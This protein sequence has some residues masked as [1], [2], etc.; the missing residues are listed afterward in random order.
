MLRYTGRNE[1]RPY[2]ENTVNMIGHDD[3]NICVDLR[4]PVGQFVPRFLYYSSS[5]VQ[6]H[7]T[8]NHRAKQTRS[9]LRA[10][11]DEIGAGLAVIV[12]L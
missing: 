6:L 9:V 7:S 3:K 12:I 5:I 11:S 1:L 8:I 2:K 4:K 10:N